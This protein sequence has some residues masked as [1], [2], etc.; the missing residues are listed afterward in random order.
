MHSYR[1]R[2]PSGTL[3]LTANGD[4]PLQLHDLLS[5]GARQNPKRPFVFVSHVLGKH[6]PA[7]PEALRAAQARLADSLPARPAVFIGMAET[8][9]GLAEGVFDCWRR[10]TTGQGVYLST[11]RYPIARQ[12][13]L[14]FKEAH[15]HATDLRLYYPQC[16]HLRERASQLDSVVLIDDELSTG[17]TFESL[18]AA[19]RRFMPRLNNVDVVALTDFSGGRV[20]RRL[21]AI[22]GIDSV[23]VSTLL[24]GSFEFQQ[25]SPVQPAA[26]PAQLQVSCR[27]SRMAPHPARLGYEQAPAVDPDNLHWCREFAQGSSVTLLGTGEC[28]YPAQLLAEQLEQEGLDVLLQSTTRSPLQIHGAI[29]CVR[30]VTDPYGEGIPNFLYNPPGAE[31]KLIIIHE[32]GRNEDI[33]KLVGELDAPALDPFRKQWLSL[34][35]VRSVA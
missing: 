35:D 8:A 2:L 22:P 3:D 10:R 12:P 13:S 18:V 34:S 29:Q 30:Q 28:M 15:S 11:T 31:R 20:A 17:K 19:L 23:R 25:T 33:R 4:D 7:R 14:D 16:Q 9:T 1:W 32:T 24:Q 6:K 26:S 21:G 5:V 27:R